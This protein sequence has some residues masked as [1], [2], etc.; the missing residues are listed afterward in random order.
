M[1]KT[2]YKQKVN[3]QYVSPAVELLHIIV[4][5]SVMAASSTGDHEGYK[6]QNVD[7]FWI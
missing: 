6:N 7:D 5:G 4:E 3:S 1:D 2:N